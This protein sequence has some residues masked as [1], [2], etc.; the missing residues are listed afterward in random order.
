LWS[1]TAS[2]SSSERG[3]MSVSASLADST[4]DKNHLLQSDKQNVYTLYH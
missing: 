4:A 2:N 1:V 3:G